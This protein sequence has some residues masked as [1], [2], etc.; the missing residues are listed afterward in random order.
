[1]GRLVAMLLPCACAAFSV[2]SGLVGRQ[3]VLR[4]ART[5]P[6]VATADGD[7]EKAASAQEKRLRA[8]R[9]ALEAERAALEAE[10]MSLELKRLKLESMEEEDRLKLKAQQKKDAEGAATTQ[11]A[12]T[13][14]P[15]ASTPAA[16][17]ST[18]APPATEAA[19]TQEEPPAAPEKQGGFP[20]NLGF[21]FDSLT[22][23]TSGDGSSTEG[24]PPPPPLTYGSIGQLADGKAE[25][26]L[27]LSA[28]Q[29]ALAK[30]RVFD[31]D[32]FYVMKA[33]QTFLGTIFR[34][35]LRTN[36]SEA[37]ARVAANVAALPELKG[38]SFLLLDD[39]ISPTLEDLQN[40]EERRPVFL[41]VPTDV[42][43]RGQNILELVAAS[44][45]LFVTSVTTLGFVLSTFILADGG[46][47]LESLEQGETAPID[48]AA[49]IA[50][51][52][53]IIFVVH[54][55]A[56]IL[57][58]L[59]NDLRTT[60]PIPIPSLQLGVFGC[61]TRLQSFAPTRQALFEF[62][63]SGPAV[64]LAL[65][66]IVYVVGIFLS[67]DLTLPPSVEQNLA[68]LTAGAAGTAGSGGGVGV[69]GAGAAGAAKTAAAAAASTPIDYSTLTPVIPTSL[70]QSSL[71]LGSIASLLLPTLTD[72][73]AVALH[74]LAVVGFVGA[75]VNALNLLPIGRL[76]GGRVALAVLG[77]SNAG[78][79]SGIALL[80]VG[81]STIFGG[82]NPI[83]LFFGLVIILLQRAQELPALDDITGVSDESK[84]AAAVSLFF[85]LLII[86][87]IPGA[88]TP[89]V[90]P[91][92]F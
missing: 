69:A 31:I 12:T 45:A 13:S 53:G 72:S 30:S 5:A 33:E 79:V 86:L 61:I 4:L 41:A 88:P 67:V 66:I 44:G 78:L 59:K 85:A 50:L 9:L 16:V 19:A 56:H 55:I 80:L 62:A 49:P 22:N 82:D 43:V 75:I 7:A 84:I 3:P 47:M 2:T 54:E 51:G 57:A 46:Q 90:P 10:K 11:A 39:P 87:P 17:S 83:L 89:L 73:P 35:N 25:D 76:D 60:V 34:G 40:A 36:S 29:L 24:L 63:I 64:A 8:E 91:P 14:T 28:D 32:S 23:L 48:A 18:D 81:L 21:N 58:A 1:M 27:Q 38:F 92:L 6:L 52:I 42:T 71:L 20:F 77:Q 26:A 37:Y 74:P 68:A 15:T 65:S 70:V